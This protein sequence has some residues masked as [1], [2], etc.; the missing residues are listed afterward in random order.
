M[1]ATVVL[2]KLRPPP[3]IRLERQFLETI[4]GLAAECGGNVREKGI[5]AVSSGSNDSSSLSN[6]VDCR[7]E[8][9]NPI[10]MDLV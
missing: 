6:I 8:D 3:S 5:G 10:P 1:V 7:N 9:G 4:A 2:V